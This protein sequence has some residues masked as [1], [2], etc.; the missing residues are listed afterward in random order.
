MQEDNERKY[1]EYIKERQLLFNAKL[2]GSQSLDKALLTLSAGALALSLTFINQIAPHP[3]PATLKFIIVAWSCFGLS[4]LST[5]LSFWT[6]Q[7]ACDKQIKILEATFLGQGDRKK[8]ANKYSCATAI[9]NLFSVLLFIGGIV[10][11][12]IF[13][14]IN[15]S[16][17]MR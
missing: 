6:S 13:S 17:H 14:A 8:L 10:S 7:K 4:I 9:L 16:V 11:F 1:Q 12:A 5:L 3:Q 2:K 15:F